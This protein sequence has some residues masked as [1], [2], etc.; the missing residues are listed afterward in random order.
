MKFL[1]ILLFL[2]LINLVIF[3][4]ASNDEFANRVHAFEAD[5][6][7]ANLN[8]D[9]QWKQNFTDGK[10]MVVAA[11]KSA[12]DE[13][14]F[15]VAAILDPT[16]SANEMKVRITGTITLITNDHK[17]DRSFGFLD[18]FNKKG[19]KWEM[20]A[21]GLAPTTESPTA[22]DKRSVESQL[23]GLENSLSR[24]AIGNDRSVLEY[25]I[26]TDFVG[27]SADGTVQDR[28]AWLASAEAQKNKAA[29]IDNV[30]VHLVSDTVAIVIG[31]QLENRTDNSSPSKQRFTRT[32]MNR[33]GH[34]Q[35][36]A[37]QLT[38]IR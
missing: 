34:W 9:Q 8:S 16:L 22:I 6:L 2:L 13:R 37:S 18:T 15:N 11:D 28:T 29:N 38:A 31:T 7:K 36:V 24:S 3:A 17:K 25:M 4:Q 35:L 10:L 32:W 20:I 27:T 19:D 30:V 12:I 21:T 1:N 5:W 33:E 26:A 14:A 23:T